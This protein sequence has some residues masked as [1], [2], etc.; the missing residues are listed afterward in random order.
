MGIFR[1]LAMILFGAL[2]CFTGFISIIVSIGLLF[3]NYSEIDPIGG[4]VFMI[5]FAF[6][7]CEIFVAFGITAIL[8]GL[9]YVCNRNEWFV[10]SINRCWGK[11]VKY[12]MILP[13]LAIAL[14]AI[15]QFIKLL[16][17]E[18]N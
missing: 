13:F 10:S 8:L 9:R 6:V 16:M 3:A 11:A 7:V 17:S 5:I 15:L 18:G 12:G 14:A 2:C 1:R 4:R